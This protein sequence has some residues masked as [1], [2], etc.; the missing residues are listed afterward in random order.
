VQDVISFLEGRPDR[1]VRDLRGQMQ[2]AAED[3]NF[4]RAAKLRDELRG[5]R[6]LQIFR[7]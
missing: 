6:E 3:L 7:Y 4:E 5:L 1:V 2:E